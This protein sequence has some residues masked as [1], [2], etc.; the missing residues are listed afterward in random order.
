METRQKEAAA[1]LACLERGIRN[2]EGRAL[3]TWL[4]DSRNREAI[5][6]AADLWHSKDVQSLLF[7]LTGVNPQ[8]RG[9][10]QPGRKLFLPLMVALVSTSALVLL[11]T[12]AGKHGGDA[13]RAALG[14]TYSTAIGEVRQVE[15][16][17]GTAITLDTNTRL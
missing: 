15:L 12:G 6:E 14:T 16:T 10:V 2:D 7:A 5:L 13:T 9:A 17:D 3:K 4:A 1:W 11:I 8:R